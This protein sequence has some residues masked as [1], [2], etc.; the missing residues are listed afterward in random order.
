MPT[1]FDLRPLP[2]S[3]VILLTDRMNDRMTE[4]NK[5]PHNSASLGGE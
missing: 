5:Q 1:V 3:R 4:Q 2:R